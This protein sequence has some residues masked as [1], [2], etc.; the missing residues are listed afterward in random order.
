MRGVLERVVERRQLDGVSRGSR[1]PIPD[2]N[3]ELVSLFV[4]LQFLRTRDVRD[5]LAGL[6]AERAT[7]SLDERE[8]RRLH[9]SLLWD[10]QFVGELRQRIEQSIWLFGQNTT[11]RAFYTSDNPVT[12]RAGDN[13]MWLKAAIFTPGT[14]VV[15]PPAPDVVMYAYPNEEP[16]L[17]LVPFS[18]RVSPVE[19]TEEMVQSE[20]TAQVFA[21]SRFV[22]SS[23]DEFDD[24]QE[25]AKTIGTDAYAQYWRDSRSGR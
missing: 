24:A 22:I 7:P 10:E 12:F 5:I 1:L 23:S 20:N 2:P 17:K 15:Y 4:A 16:W 19:L 18:E 9:T 11:S 25:F 21:A 6:G 13:S 3:R 14:Y 8:R